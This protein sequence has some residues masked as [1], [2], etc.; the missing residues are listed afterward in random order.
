MRLY[1]QSIVLNFRQTLEHNT[2]FHPAILFST[3][4]AVDIIENREEIKI[5]EQ[6]KN[7]A[8]NPPL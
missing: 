1:I 5:D 8:N 3:L 2:V 4:K 7:Q 6:E